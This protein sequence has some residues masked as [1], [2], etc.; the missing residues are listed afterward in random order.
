MEG[1]SKCLRRDTITVKL[2]DKTSLE[3]RLTEFMFGRVGKKSSWG[4]PFNLTVR[5]N[6]SE[7]P[8]KAKVSCSP[9]SGTAEV[10]FV[11]AGKLE[12]EVFLKPRTSDVNEKAEELFPLFAAT[13]L[14]VM[15]LYGVGRATR[16]GFG[17]FALIEFEAGKRGEGGTDETLE[18]CWR[19]RTRSS[20]LTLPTP[21]SS[22]S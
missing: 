14:V 22:M 10:P 11:D 6:L 7:D 20:A 12:V 18:K 16:W 3:L 19:R 13:A 1:Q 8:S 4:S 2:S 21:P 9:P 5:Y 15:T 17:R